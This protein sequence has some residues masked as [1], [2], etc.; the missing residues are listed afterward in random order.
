MR[1]GRT[2]NSVVETAQ[3]ASGKPR[4][5]RRTLP[6]PSRRDFHYPTPLEAGRKTPCAQRVGRN[7][8]LQRLPELRSPDTHWFRHKVFV[9]SYPVALLR[10]VFR[11]QGVCTLL[12]SC[13]A[14]ARISATLF[15][16]TVRNPGAKPSARHLGHKSGCG[17]CLRRRSAL[18]YTSRAIS[19]ML[20]R[21]VWRLSRFTLGSARCPCRSRANLGQRSIRPDP[22]TS[23]PRQRPPTGRPFGIWSKRPGA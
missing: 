5:E 13:A 2:A 1:G 22:A 19:A 6:A 3:K 9:R 23:I 16:P 17:R 8:Q 18:R 4:D 7:E 10:H 21:R 20:N 12:P 11:P 15:R 14:A